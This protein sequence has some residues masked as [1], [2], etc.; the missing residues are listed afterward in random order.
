MMSWGNGRS[1]EIQSEKS[2]N[3]STNSVGGVEYFQYFTADFVGVTKQCILLDSLVLCN[4]LS[5]NSD[6]V[7]RNIY[8]PWI[9]SSIV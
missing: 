7:C 9:K 2:E 1:F 4:D 6:H 5:L 3:S 8:G